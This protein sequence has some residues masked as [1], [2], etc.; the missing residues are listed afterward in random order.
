MHHLH[1]YE[2]HII[3]NAD[4]VMGCALL[5]K[6]GRIAFF[7]VESRTFIDDGK[8]Q[9]ELYSGPNLF[10]LRQRYLLPFALLI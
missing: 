4:G 5:W 7:K 8:P 9:N 6:R 1:Q 10:T 3:M 2:G